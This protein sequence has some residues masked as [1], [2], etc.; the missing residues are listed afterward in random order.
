[1]GSDYKLLD[2]EVSYDF[3]SGG[4]VSLELVEGSHVTAVSYTMLEEE[5]V[6]IKKRIASVDDAALRIKSNLALSEC[7]ILEVSIRMS[8]VAEY[9]SDN[10]LIRVIYEGNGSVKND[11]K[12]KVYYDSR[13]KLTVLLEFKDDAREIYKNIKY[14]RFAQFVPSKYQIKNGSIDLNKVPLNEHYLPTHL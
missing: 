8:K 5:V 10:E 6:K 14:F 9:S 1:M 3:M 7:I 12:D 13:N 4:D 11:A 2:I